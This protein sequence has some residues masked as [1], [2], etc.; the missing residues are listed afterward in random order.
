MG[1]GVKDGNFAHVSG[2]FDFDNKK[3]TIDYV[4][5]VKIAVQSENFEDEG[6]ELIGFDGERKQ[7]FDK[8]VNP[9]RN[10]CAPHA[11]SGTFDEYISVSPQLRL[12]KLMVKGVEAAQFTRGTSVSPGL[13]AMG[14][15]DPDSPNRFPLDPAN[16][17][18]HAPGVTYTVQAKGEQE[19][20]WQT[21]AVGLDVPKTDIDVN[22]FPGAKS[23][24]VRVL[25]SDG[26][27]ESQVFEEKKT[28]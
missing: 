21:I 11:P 6:L 3:G 20:N 15:P 26:F 22:Q 24:S 12:I 1:A 8:K 7:I 27:S 25:Q 19:P 10:S 2:T 18:T 17:F 5:P 23:V 4:T 14:G 16:A 13:I 28:F 9:Q